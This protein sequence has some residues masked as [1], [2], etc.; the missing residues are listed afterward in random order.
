M[1]SPVGTSGNP[2]LCGIV[3]RSVFVA[4]AA[5]AATCFNIES[6]LHARPGHKHGDPFPV[7]ITISAM[8]PFESVALLSGQRPVRRRPGLQQKPYIRSRSRTPT[9]VADSSAAG[10]KP[11]ELLVSVC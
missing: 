10:D 9:L 7:R 6:P 2:S 4:D 1:L 8:P 11:D 3:W 5:A